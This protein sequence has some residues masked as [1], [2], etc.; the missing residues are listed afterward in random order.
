M[1]LQLRFY[2]G[3]DR[4]IQ[5]FQVNKRPYLKLSEFGVIQSCPYAHVHTHAGIHVHTCA[6]E[7]IYIYIHE[8]IE[9]LKSVLIKH[10][11]Q[12]IHVNPGIVYF[13]LNLPHG[14]CD[15]Q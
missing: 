2:E 11:L 6:P 12:R 9:G 3:R 15:G 5:Q 13:S 10:N 8:H 1:G 7:Q 4:R 14:L